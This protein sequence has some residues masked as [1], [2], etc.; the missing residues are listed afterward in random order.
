MRPRRNTVQKGKNGL[1]KEVR[2]RRLAERQP[3]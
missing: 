3:S 2:R 1:R